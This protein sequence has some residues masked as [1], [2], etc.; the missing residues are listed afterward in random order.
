MLPGNVHD[1]A[2]ARENALPVLRKYTDKMPALADCGYEGAG[3]GVL[4]PV[5]KPEGVNELDINARTRNMLLSSARVNIQPSG[6]GPLPAGL[7]VWRKG[8]LAGSACRVAYGG[9]ALIS[10]RYARCAR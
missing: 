3:H 7:R 1:L 8:L 9:P 4:T 5:K 10:Y 6:R 2:A